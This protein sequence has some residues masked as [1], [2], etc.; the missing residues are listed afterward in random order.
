MDL[1][2]HT[3]LN[4]QALSESDAEA[5]FEALLSGQLDDARIGAL[6]SLIQTRGASSPELTGAARAMRRHSERIPYKIK[7][8]DTGQEDTIN[9]YTHCRFCAAQIRITNDKGQWVKEWE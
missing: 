3:L 1:H 6:L 7:N 4:G 2:F 5:L 8:N 9:R